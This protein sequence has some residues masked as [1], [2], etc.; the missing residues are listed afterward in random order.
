MSAVTSQYFVPLT[1]L[2]P[3]CVLLLSSPAYIDHHG[4]PNIRRGDSYCRHCAA[5]DRGYPQ[6]GM[7]SQLST[8]AAS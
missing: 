2:T 5:R 6:E 1:S 3:Y 7:L 4:S 8:P